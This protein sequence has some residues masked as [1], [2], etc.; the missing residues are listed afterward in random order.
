MS[1]C[2]EFP[3]MIVMG[4]QSENYWSEFGVEDQGVVTMSPMGRGWG[5]G[6]ES[7]LTLT[8]DSKARQM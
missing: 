5:G 3:H 8:A 6:C 7:R 4:N 2:F 1:V